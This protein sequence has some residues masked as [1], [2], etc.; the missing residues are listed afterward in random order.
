M[1]LRSV[2]IGVILNIHDLT[3]A[4]GAVKPIDLYNEDRILIG[5]GIR[6]GDQ[7]RVILLVHPR[8]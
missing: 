5:P 2:R 7:I 8:Y 6:D 4:D 3:S 1:R